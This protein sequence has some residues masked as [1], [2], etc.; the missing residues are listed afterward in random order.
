[1]PLFPPLNECFNAP[2]KLEA[3]DED[4][5]LAFHAFQADVRTEAHHLPFVAPAGVLFLEPQDVAH[6]EFD[7]SHVYKNPKLTF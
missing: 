7:K 5:V 3:V 2:L 1:L 6:F 4:I